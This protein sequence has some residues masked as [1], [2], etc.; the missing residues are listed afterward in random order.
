[1]ASVCSFHRLSILL[2]WLG[3]FFCHLSLSLTRER[4]KVVF[5]PVVCKRTCHKGYCH[6]VCKPGSNMTLIAENGGSADT[7]TGSGFRVVVCPQPCMNGGQCSSNNHCICPPDYTGRFCQLPAVSGGGRNAGEVGEGEGMDPS[8]GK[9]AVYA[10]QVITGEDEPDGRGAKI[11]QSA[12]TVP[13]GP[14]HTSAEVQVLPPLLNVRVHHPPNASIQV[15]RIEGLGPE[16]T[17]VGS[18]QHLIPYPE[19]NKA[20]VP[21]PITYKPL[22]RC[23]QDT[24][25]KQACGTNPLPGLTKEEDCCGSVGIAWGQ[26][27]C[28]KCPQLSNSG[29]QKTAPFR[30]EAGSDCPLG[31]KRLNS[32]HC[33]DINECSMQG[34]CQNGECLNTQ[35]SFR[36]S[37]KHGYIFISS[38]MHCAQEKAELMGLCFR[39]VGPEG[40]CQHPLS[41]RMTRQLCC[42]SVGKAWGPQCEACPVD[43]TASFTEICPAGKG[44]HI[45]M[46]HQTLTIQGQ[47]DFTLHLHPEGSDTLAPP[48]RV[49]EQALPFNVDV[50]PTQKTSEMDSPGGQEVTP[51]ML[52]TYGTNSEEKSID[53][54]IPVSTTQQISYPE[55][56]LQP[57][58]VAVR[59][60]PPEYHQNSAAEIAPIQVTATDECKLTRNLCGYGECISTPTGYECSCYTGY[61]PHPVSKHCVDINECEG[62]PCGPGKAVCLNTVGSFNCHCLHGY[63][64]QVMQEKRSCVDIN[65]CLRSGVC[66]DPRNCLNFPGNYKCVCQT[67]YK[68][69]STGTQMC[70]D[71]NECLLPNLCVGGQCVNTPGSYHCVCPQGYK[72]HQHICQDVDEC[73]HHPELCSPH[74]TCENTEGSY[75]CT[76]D[77]G[78]IPSDDRKRCEEAPRGLDLRD[79]F[80]SLDDSL[81][82]DSVLAV[83]VTREQCC[84]SLGAGW[85]DHCEIYP[86]PVHNSAEFLTL[87]P[88]GI[89]FIVDLGIMSYGLPTYRDI[90]ECQ[91]FGQEICKEGK[92]VN[93]QPS[94][95]CYCKH[96]YYYDTRLLQCMDV[97]ECVDE[98]NCVNGQCINT[99][100]SFYCRC[101]PHM[102]YHSEHKICMPSADLDL[103][104]LDICWKMRGADGICSYAMNGPQLSLTECCCRLGQGWGHRCLSCP[105]QHAQV[106]SVFQER[107][108]FWESSSLSVKKS[109]RGG[110]SSEEISDEC[111]CVNGRCV[112]SP[113]G[114]SCECQAG[115]QLD[116][117]RTRCIDLDECRQKNPRGPLCKNS[118]CINTTGSFRCVCK[119]GYARSR[120]PHIC[121]PQRKR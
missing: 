16:G 91:L 24:L 79:C 73:L 47:S 2:L 92:C 115:F 84:C 78:Y 65:E 114:V 9:H 46:S 38:K 105:P 40:Q 12:L 21:W 66:G 51:V 70:E 95:E 121:I 19:G 103:E 108:S 71:I 104:N 58:T 110:D 11:S 99:R 107:N 39:L 61:Q 50:V 14:G 90:D 120:H 59:Q 88:D 57:T 4:F 18:S 77:S 64:L 41:K 63:R 52:P 26:H 37:C 28:H 54:M 35:G 32:T 83:N 74:G 10:V 25:P 1:M 56:V 23:F 87:C 111:P 62:D 49:S 20:S 89:G 117:T 98:S 97:D 106:C 43:G 8:S 5:A 7:L 27:K 36:C 85:G 118:R 72:L 109:R 67:G 94:Y 96:G 69:R 29:T 81:F 100:G 60:V 102:Q 42:C 101:P 55:I 112:R 48:P 113:H 22:G 34:V 13:L 3:T 17:A 93:T 30:G 6:D 76:C 53:L 80:L 15:H 68:M 119:P 45:L 82:C 44:Y 116:I 33:Q 86:C 31:Y 75:I